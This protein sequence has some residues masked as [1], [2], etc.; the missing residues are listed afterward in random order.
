MMHSVL[1]EKF[2]ILQYYKRKSR[3]VKIKNLNQLWFELLLKGILR[4]K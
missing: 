3:R 4:V 2:N 1:L